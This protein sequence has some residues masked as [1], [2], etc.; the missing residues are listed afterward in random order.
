MPLTEMQIK[1]LK[2]RAGRD[3]T[4]VSDGRG[5]YIVVMAT[6]EKYWYARIYENGRER[7]LS[8]GR[9][10]DIGIKE[11]RELRY[12]LKQREK[13][14]PVIFGTLAQEWFADHYAGLT[15]G[16]VENMRSIL[17]RFLL[18]AF[19]GRDIRGI[20]AQDVFAL[21]RA[22]QDKS[23]HTGK[24]ANAMLSRIFQYGIARGL[25]EWNPA[26][27][28]RGALLPVR[29]TEHYSVVRTEDA[30]REVLR[31]VDGY[32]GKPVVRLGLLLL[33]YTFVRPGELIRA[34]WPELDLDAGEWRI[35]PER[36]KMKRPH[37]VPLSTQ[38]LA[39]FQELREIVP[40]P[41]WCLALPF[42]DA[43]ISRILLPRALVRLGYGKGKM[44]P[45]GFRGMA[46]TLLNE[47]GFPP[48]VI[49]RQL[50]H[51]ERNA[52]RAAY[53]RAEYMDE[54]RGMMQWW[55]DYVDGLIKK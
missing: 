40:H 30:A 15:K 19:G 37:V 47:N 13:E 10:P 31:A 49:E 44:T 11:A 20:T 54:R 3:R 16:T 33:A 1:N 45:H 12:T 9:W 7:R 25:C 41:V 27:Q 38:A 55:G 23:R 4:W 6:G 42:K 46:S 29:A 52:V 32:S 14:A 22:L 26:A 28:I 18:P 53:N 24:R 21:T 35:P 34:Q 50:A 48:D 51:V 8:L 17:D 39:L 36:M 5:L 2:P 43:P